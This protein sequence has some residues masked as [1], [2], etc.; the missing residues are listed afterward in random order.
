MASVYKPTGRKRYKIAYTDPATGARKVVSGYRDKKAS[1]EKARQLETE[2]ERRAA[3]LHVNAIDPTSLSQLIT[4]YN[5]ALDRQGVG[6]PNIRRQKIS[7]LRKIADA[8]KWQ[9]LAHITS[10]SFEELLTQKHAK[11]CAGHT[12]NSYLTTTTQFL[13]W[14]I[15]TG[16]LSKNPLAKVQRSS[17]KRTSERRAY[18]TEEFFSLVENSRRFGL[19]YKIAGLSGLRKGELK[20]LTRV[21]LTPTG[22][23]AWHL[24]ASITKSKRLDRIP[25]LPE[26]AEAIMPLWS[27]MTTDSQKL[28]P[29][30]P[31]FYVIRSDL[32]RAGITKHR[33]DGKKVDF[34]SLRYFFCTLLAKHL[35][36]QKV[37]LLMRHKTL[38]MTADIYCDLGLEDVADDIWDLPAILQKEKKILE[39]NQ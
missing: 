19:L 32:K 15:A 1:I 36:I 35:P 27:S 18:T 28:F 23:P 9:K 24:R 10:K 11:G 39:A 29:Q 3:G 4:E 16:L 33:D 5:Q 7:R 6:Q 30:V 20:Q 13:E 31:G 22:R 25:M 12:L 17:P 8:C 21:D 34:H 2:A 14:A 37:K 26:C 38:Q